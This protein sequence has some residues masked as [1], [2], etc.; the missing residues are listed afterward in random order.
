MLSVYSISL[1]VL[2]LPLFL[3]MSK[4]VFLSFAIL[5][6][7][8]A[9]PEGISLGIPPLKAAYCLSSVIFTA[10]LPLRESFDFV[11]ADFGGDGFFF[12][13]TSVARNV[14]LIVDCH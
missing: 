10:A 5:P 6:K 13:S 11:F 8:S 2:S 12:G 3:Q 4:I 14:D 7:T 9:V 1:P